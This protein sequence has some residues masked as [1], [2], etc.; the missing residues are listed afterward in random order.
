MKVP[1]DCKASTQFNGSVKK[2]YNISELLGPIL[3]EMSLSVKG[4]EKFKKVFQKC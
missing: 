1:V 4:I 3:S 2:N